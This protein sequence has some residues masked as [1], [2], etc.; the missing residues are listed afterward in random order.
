MCGILGSKGKFS[1][2]QIRAAAK[3]IAHRGPDAFA[4][5]SEKDIIFA[6]HRLAILD[7]SANGTQPYHFDYLT[8]V[9]NGE[10]YNF[11][12][13]RED[14]RKEGYDFISDSDT[15]VL[16]KSFHKWGVEAV[17]RFIGMFAFAIYDR[18]DDSVYLFRDRIGVK[19]LYYSLTGG[20]TF[21][22]EL[23]TILPLL[24]NRK[25]DTESVYEYFRVGYISEDKTIYRDARKLKPGHYLHYRNGEATIA[26]FWNIEEI[27]SQSGNHTEDQWKDLLHKQ[28]IDAFGLRMVSDVPVGVFLSGGVD[29]SLVTSILQ[30]HYGHVHTFTISFDDERYNEAPYAKKIAEHLGTTHTEFTLQMS[31]AYEVLEKFYDIYDEPFA[32]SSGIPST[33]VSHLAAKEGIK[34]VL[35]A[36]GGDELFAGY[37][38][39]QTSVNLY[40]KLNTLPPFA[41]SIIGM[42]TKGLYK[43][44]LLRNIYRGNLEH[45]IATLNEL[46]NT[47]HLGDFYHAFLSNQAN[48]ELDSLL[49]DRTEEKKTRLLNEDMS[50]LMLKDIHH[51]LPDDLLVKMDR[52][53]MY[54]S[55]EGREP[56]LDHR[57]V[58]MACRMPLSVKYKNGQSKWILKEILAEYV[59]KEYFI[60]PKKGFSIPIFKWFS[61]HMDHLFDIYLSPEKIKATGIFNE[62]EVEREV[63]KYKWNKRN[64]KESNIEKM[65]RLLSFM[66]W[67]E[68]WHLA[69]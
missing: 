14:L 41:K 59:P 57:I 13:I 44:N 50:G 61:E 46:V 26:Q 24:S 19:P 17:D 27:I 28:M 60:R 8:L 49:L 54:N 2:D 5:H 35:S 30:K 63:R 7:L 16:I 34:V 53:T 4:V 64:G 52:A 45:K 39:Y 1:E 58:E 48:L 55:I 9:Y 40:N 6:H 10:I 18:R 68:K 47:E 37:N 31:D 22:S 12:D 62:K 42:G 15:E 25:I 33:V 69:K 43:S 36:D 66:M 32:D 51:Y 65:W 21:G 29:S 3:T 20:L 56:F 11:K 67:W 38:H 23:R